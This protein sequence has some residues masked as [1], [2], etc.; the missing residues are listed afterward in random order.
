[1]TAQRIPSFDPT[2]PRGPLYR[3]LSALL[4]TDFGRWFAIDVAAPADPWLLRL[5]RGR[6][7][8]GLSLPSAALTTVGARSGTRR[9]AAILYFTDADDVILIASNFGRER[10]PAWY[11][12][13]RAHPE[14]VLQRAGVRARYRASEVTDPAECA[15]L[16]DLAISVAPVYANYRERTE[17]IGRRIPILR[18]T[19]AG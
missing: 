17:R 5:T 14:A 4:L 15:R 2:A 3:A 7:G 16:Y 10:H 12:N 19:P 11:H 18:L 13:L 9:T 6:V 1:M 8:L